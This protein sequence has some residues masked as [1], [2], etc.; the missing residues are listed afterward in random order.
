MIPGTPD[1]TAFLKYLS[2]IPVLITLVF[3][4]IS[5]SVS[6]QLI[7]TIAGSG[8]NGNTGNGGP[9]LCAGTPYPYD[10]YVDAAGDVYIALGNCIRKVNGTTGIITA[11]AGSDSYGYAGD[12]G[13]ATQALFK[14]VFAICGDDAGNIYATEYSGHRIRKINVATGIVTTIAG[15]GT[16]GYSGDGGPAINAQINTPHGIY[17]D[18]QGNI[19]FADF[20]NQRIRKIAAGTGIITTV[21][22]NGSS[23]HSGDNG[24]AINAGIPYPVDV[25]TDAA[26]NI[27]FTEV[28]GSNTCRIRKIDIATGI[29]TTIAGTN[30]YGHSGD[31]GLAV[32]ANLFDPHSVCIDA[33][34]NIYVSQYD[35]GRIRKIDAATGIINTIAGTGTLGFSGDGDLAIY[36]TLHYPVGICLDAKNALYVADNS[37]HRVRKIDFTINTPANP[38]YSISI[39]GSANNICAGTPVTFN[40]TGGPAPGQGISYTW[41]KNGFAVLVNTLSYTDNALANGDVI[42]CEL[43]NNTTCLPGVAQ[44]NAITMTVNPN[45]SPAIS[46]AVSN[47]PVCN[48]STV[49]FTATP[50]QAGSNPV[51][52]WKLNGNNTGTNAA[53]FSTASIT[54]GDI[55]SCEINL[56]PSTACAAKT[57]AIS[58][59]IKVTVLSNAV[60][61]VTISSPQDKICSGAPMTFSAQVQNVNNNIHYQWLLNG[62][63]TGSDLNTYSNTVLQNGDQVSCKVTSTTLCPGIEAISNI[64]TMTVYPIP[65]IDVTGADKLSIM[66]GQQAKIT[67][68]VTGNID[69]YTWSPANALVNANTF[70]PVTIPLAYSTTYTLSVTSVDGCTVSKDITVKVHRIFKMPNAFT[71]NKDGTNDVFRIPTGTLLQLKEFAVFD[72]WG[73]R[74]FSTT[75]ISAGW[76]GMYKGRPANT[77]TYV[78]FI[79]GMLDDKDAVFKGTVQLIR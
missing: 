7:T 48:G 16:S 29:I 58:N 47:N 11:F 74:V 38:S 20:A 27:F 73:N 42:T 9:A 56:A 62:S 10:V 60:P 36:A 63:A 53:V 76:D 79:T 22:G 44:S 55:I 61:T 28:N 14:F 12:G 67:T 70:T 39:S 37:N 54:D 21:G 2:R 72:R 18:K 52:Q 8:H 57:S 24:L 49:T 34:G 5:H 66:A 75:D 4:L 71:P 68:S 43:A 17:V 3:L 77:G 50:V 26:G 51:Y 78:Y 64:I 69:T 13:Q 31:G 59:N 46:I 45:L 40:A 15:T 1:T 30:V 65:V 25:C 32:N 41:K 19:Y 6:A 23:S 35:D 33:A